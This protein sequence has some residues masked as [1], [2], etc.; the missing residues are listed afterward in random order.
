MTATVRGFLS[1]I[2]AGNAHGHG[3][4]H[5]GG[6]KDVNQG[7]VELEKEA[8]KRAYSLFLSQNVI[9]ELLPPVIDFEKVQDLFPIAVQKI[10]HFLNRE[11]IPVAPD[12]VIH[13][14]TLLSA[15]GNNK[16]GGGGILGFKLL[17]LEMDLEV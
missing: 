14:S 2:G 3:D 6:Q 15:A 5:G 12:Q 1:D 13:D 11:I 7:L 10:D 4:G 17:L 16:K 9:A 8:E